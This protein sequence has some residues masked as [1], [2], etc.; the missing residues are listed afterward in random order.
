MFQKAFVLTILISTII[1]LPLLPDPQNPIQ[2]IW[3]NSVDQQ[4]TLE[5]KFQFAPGSKTLTYNQVIGIIFPSDIA[6]LKLS[7]G[8]TPKW[9]CVFS[10][11]D[12]GKQMTFTAVQGVE[13]NV[14]YCRMDDIQSSPLAVGVNYKLSLQINFTVASNLWSNFGLFTATNAAASK[15]YLDTQPVF[16]IVG[17]YGDYRT[18]INKS[19]AVTSS[20]FINKSNTGGNVIYPW[21][22]FDLIIG[23]QANSYIR[24]Q[25]VQLVIY[26]PGTMVTPPTSVST[27]TFDAS[28]SALTAAL[29]GTLGISKFTASG[30]V[31]TGISEDFI[32]GRSF[33]LTLS[34]WTAKDLVEDDDDIIV[35]LIYKNSYS[36]YSYN[37]IDIIVKRS[38]LTVTA[39]HP[40]NWDIWRNA[41]WPIKFTVTSA[42]DLNEGYLAIQHTNAKDGLNRLSFIASTC[43]LSANSSMD[44]GIGKRSQCFPLRT[45]FNY[46]SRSGVYSGSGVFLKISKLAKNTPMILTIW[47]FADNCGGDDNTNYSTYDLINK[48]SNSSVNFE[49]TSGFLNKIDATKLYEDR[50]INL[51]AVSPST[52]MTGKCYNNKIQGSQPSSI[53]WRFDDTL[54]SKITLTNTNTVGSADIALF[55]EI[56]DWGISSQSSSTSCSNGLS[57]C[58]ATDINKNAFNERFL[59]SGSPLDAN[60]Y[61]IMKARIAKQENDPFYKTFAMPY[62]SGETSKIYKHRMA[63]VFSKDWFTAGDDNSNCYLSWGMVSETLDDQ[64]KLLYINPVPK[65]ITTRDS[66]TNF[67]SVCNDSSKTTLDVNTSILPTS[68]STT[69]YKI[70]S[71]ISSGVGTSMLFSISQS[72]QTSCNASNAATL[73]LFTTCLKWAATLPTI[74]SMYTYIEFQWQYHYVKSDNSSQINRNNRFIKLY[75]EGGV[76]NDYTSVTNNPL[77]STPLSLHLIWT[78]GDKAVCLLELDGST[79]FNSMTNDS[80]ILALWI[81]HGVL[82]ETDYSDASSG[83]PTAPMSIYTSFGLQS[84][85]PQSKDNNV[86]AG[87]TTYTYNLFNSILSDLQ[88]TSRANN[89]THY[90]FFLGSLLLINRTGTPFTV[91]ANNPAPN[92][93]IPIYCPNKDDNNQ[94]TSN[95]LPAVVG[96]WMK[97]NTYSDIGKVNRYLSYKQ[98]A[99]SVIIQTS[100]DNKDVNGTVN[101]VALRFTPYSNKSGAADDN[102]LFIFNSTKNNVGTR[103]VCSSHLLFLNKSQSSYKVDNILFK[104]LTPNASYVYDSAKVFYIFGKKFNSAV[105]TTLTN[106]SAVEVSDYSKSVSDYYYSGIDRPKVEDSPMHTQDQFAYFCS[107]KRYG[108][109]LMLSNWTGNGFVLDYNPTTVAW[110]KVFIASDKPE[111]NYKGDNAGSA[112]FI[113]QTP[114]YAPA[115]SEIVFSLGKSKF[116]DQSI[117]GIQ[118]GNKVN[119]CYL[120]I[121]NSTTYVSCNND[122]AT[123][124]F[125]VC[126]YNMY[127]DTSITFSS[128]Y[129]NFPLIDTNTINTYLNKDVYDAEIQIADVNNNPFTFDTKQA[130]AVDAGITAAKIT[131]IA[132]TEPVQRGSFGQVTFTI[133]LPRDAVRNMKLL[134]TGDMKELVIP[135]QQPRCFVNL[136]TDT[137]N[138]DAAG[139][140][141]IDSCDVSGLSQNSAPITITTKNIIYKCGLSFSRTINVSLWPVNYINFDDNIYNTRTYSVKMYTNNGATTGYDLAL[142][143]VA[144]AMPK[145][146]FTKSD[147][148]ATQLDTLCPVSAISQKIPGEFAE[149]TFAF[150]LITNKDKLTGSVAPNRL[151]IIFPNTLYNPLQ[152]NI[153]CNVADVRVNCIVENEDTITLRFND[154]I[155]INTTVNVRIA[156]LKNPIKTDGINFLCLVQRQDWTNQTNITTILS[157]SGKN[158]AGNLEIKSLIAKGNLLVLNS[159]QKINSTVPRATATYQFL[160]ALDDG[161]EMSTR[162]INFDKNPKIIVSFPDTYNLALYNTTQK[163]ASVKLYSS[164]TN[165]VITNSDLT[166]SSVTRLGNKI[167]MQL[168]NPMTIDINW[169][170]LEINISNIVN[171]VNSLED[172]GNASGPIHVM[173]INSDESVMLRTYDNTIADVS[174]KKPNIKDDTD[175]AYLAYYKGNVFTWDNS[176]YVIDFNTKLNEPMRIRNGR[177]T[178]FDINMRSN[179][180]P[181][182]APVDGVIILNDPMFMSLN[183][184]NFISSSFNESQPMWIG[185]ACATPPGQYFITFTLNT[186]KPELFHPLP[187][188]TVIVDNTKANISYKQ[189]GVVSQGGSTY[190]WYDLSEPN[191]DRLTITWTK[192]VNNDP[193]AKL[194][195]TTIFPVTMPRGTDRHDNISL[196]SGSGFSTFSITSTLKVPVQTYTTVDPNACYTWV[197][198]KLIIEVN[199]VSSDIIPSYDL[200]GSFTYFNSETNH[201]LKK[202]SI[203]FTFT[204]PMAP[205]YLYCAL[206]CI[207]RP[208]LTSSMI[209]DT[210]KEY[211]PTQFA[212]YYKSYYDTTLPSDIIFEGL[213]RNQKYRLTCLM[214]S[215]DIAKPTGTMYVMESYLDPTTNTNIPLTPAQT[216]P[217]YCIEYSFNSAMNLNNLTT[218]HQNVINKCQK[219]ISSPTGW[220]S[221]GCAVCTDDSLTIFAPGLNLDTAVCYLKSNTPIT[222]TLRVLDDTT[223]GNVHAVAAD[224]NTLATTT[225]TTTTSTPT[226]TTVSTTVNS[227]T[228]I[229]N[230]NNGVNLPPSK[231]TFRYCIAHKP[232]CE[233]DRD[234]TYE[235][236]TKTY[237]QMANDIKNNFGGITGEFVNIDTV[238]TYNDGIKPKPENIKID[239]FM[240]TN[241]GSISWNSYY[242]TPLSCAW[243]YRAQSYFPA[244]S[245]DNI[246]ACATG[247]CGKT[248]VS[249]WGIRTG[250]N[251]NTIYPLSEGTT[252]EIFYACYNDMPNAQMRSDSVKVYSWLVPKT[253]PYVP[254]MCLGGCDA[255]TFGFNFILFALVMML[256]A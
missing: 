146:T 194:T 94:F 34:G 168:A 83:Y 174:S 167:I 44:Q 62:T 183:N 50:L 17:Q 151:Q 148:L 155:K 180:D 92:L 68:T 109:N 139:N 52:A 200:S 82:L 102:T 89:K 162:P 240:F 154:D 172:L 150:D 95:K 147:V 80:N 132:Y 90:H 31:I 161:V 153:E 130:N 251:Q 63:F 28:N 106:I 203:G 237:I 98:G 76:F 185:T 186:T 140:Y 9:G 178:K 66:D 120:T 93:L 136:G 189:K 241:D 3:P 72:G 181:N 124:T 195:D 198:N 18:S 14:A 125:T 249:S 175:A 59:Y 225:S 25:D 40:E 144:I 84:A 252:Y 35:A 128:L 188:M 218:A 54:L 143:N 254:P 177:Y 165:K 73:G 7:D 179:A 246:W 2:L 163:T 250:T 97:I 220:Q 171:P 69:S 13:N 201:N 32:P 245:F 64:H 164:D 79:I 60:S 199:G 145:Y 244:P 36:V 142:N 116:L 131:G 22:T 226:S 21:N 137:S 233:T 129:L 108:E 216:Y 15:L 221:K 134:I 138:T 197:N 111:D 135:N 43:D 215:S 123:N 48:L 169:R 176:K 112:R 16:G 103:T 24:S 115:N 224:A 190:I 193:T 222:T 39:A 182:I 12:T 107:S 27:N 78:S 159:S 223:T 55:R 117:C 110:P 242:N 213:M 231:T 208:I 70:M 105:Y 256:L 49:F 58:Y 158:N 47:A 121:E 11:E 19:L 209:K 127:I 8:N 156:G 157:G 196:N 253:I 235:D 61:F 41:A 20:T 57:D 191:F 87:S 247:N 1:S 113:I 219:T 205:V 236:L 71:T 75:P 29:V 118:A 227:D 37:T 166:V 149:Y 99:S 30:I 122:L 67:I 114:T 170:Y 96:A 204:P 100:K 53:A 91:G 187:V 232:T 184:Y 86:Y 202:N 56:Y 173:I 85:I 46:P 74:K 229:L 234:V 228:T 6:T 214:E 207:S 192:D 5:L 77:N 119:N 45:D 160:L 10:N 23:L 239:N 230:N 217:T 38:S 4:K 210:F 42:V 211:F 141:L 104:G 152:A 243:Q 51:L 33:L 26:Y 101:K 133:T 65:A 248:K 126:C 255:S 81:Y 212:F 238:S 88:D 206:T